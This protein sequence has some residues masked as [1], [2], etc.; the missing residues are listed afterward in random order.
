MLQRTSRTVGAQER[1]RGR[2]QPHR[3]GHNLLDMLAREPTGCVMSS[4]KIAPH[5]T[6]G[7]RAIVSARILRHE[8]KRTTPK[9]STCTL[10]E[11]PANLRKKACK[12]WE[13]S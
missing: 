5:V 13:P 12:L 9:E 6:E 1:P 10:S 8:R 4:G 3:L 11:S 2:R 7:S